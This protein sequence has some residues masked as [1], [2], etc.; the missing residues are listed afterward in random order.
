MNEDDI[1]KQNKDFFATET[2]I[3]PKLP[4]QEILGLLRQRKT[5]GELCFD[6]QQGGVR[7][8]RLS[9]KTRD[10]TEAEREEI[11]NILGMK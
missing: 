5:T 4:A 3:D 1:I 9:E 7:R 8:I 10:L 2:T 11:R 6:L